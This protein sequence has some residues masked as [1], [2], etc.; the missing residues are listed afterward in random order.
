MSLTL[1]LALV[2][3]VMIAVADVAAA[4]VVPVRV[5]GKG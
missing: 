4:G 5:P 3:G 1:L 2:V